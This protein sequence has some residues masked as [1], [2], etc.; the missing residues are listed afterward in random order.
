MKVEDIKLR[1]KFSKM[2][3]GDEKAVKDVSSNDMV[4][5]NFYYYAL[6]GA[7]S[8]QDSFDA[9]IDEIAELILSC[10]AACVMQLKEFV[11]DISGAGNTSTDDVEEFHED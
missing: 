3:D 6:Y 4:M 1:E 2:L 9:D 10:D 8:I 5:F 7:Y 11:S